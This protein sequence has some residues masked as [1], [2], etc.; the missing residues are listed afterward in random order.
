VTHTTVFRAFYN[1]VNLGSDFV[2]AYANSDGSGRLFLF[3]A[4]EAGCV[5]VTTEAF[6]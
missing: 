4:G 2:E 6:Y 1:R 5:A 3:P